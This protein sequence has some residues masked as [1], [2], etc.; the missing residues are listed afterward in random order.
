VKDVNWRNMDDASYKEHPDHMVLI[1]TSI[2]IRKSYAKYIEYNNFRYE[3]R[4]VREQVFYWAFLKAP[5]EV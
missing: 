5:D 3:D 4:S 1:F 2:A